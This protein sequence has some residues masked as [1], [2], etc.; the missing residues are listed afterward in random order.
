MKRLTAILMLALLPLGG[1]WAAIDAFEFDNPVDERRYQAL[2][3][4]LRCT[5][6]QNQS[7][8]DS[9]ADLALDLRRKVYE[10]IL[11]GRSDSE[12]TDYMV[13][14]YGDF[15]L[16]RPPVTPVTY[17]LWYGP[18]ALFLLGTVVLVVY[19][20]RRGRAADGE[21]E[22]LTDEERKR[23]DDLLDKGDGR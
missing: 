16:Y 7:L 17:G 6:C 10:M 1:A 23:L 8:A 13:A 4:E 9:N 3:E 5:V 18:V 22:T 15:V 12:I 14:R 20:R 11:D 21:P 19:V 2:S